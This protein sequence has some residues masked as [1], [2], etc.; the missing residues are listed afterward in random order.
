MTMPTTTASPGKCSECQEPFWISETGK[1][2]PNGHGRVILLSESERNSLPI[3]VS[4]SIELSIRVCSECD[5]VGIVPCE[6]CDG[7]GYY[8]CFEC[9]NEATC[10]DCNGIG[11][12]GC[13]SCGKPKSGKGSD[14]A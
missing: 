10:P 8:E 5:G 11:K 1:F 13:P 7:E 3:T 14:H 2:C 12:I 9:G 4:S 6:K